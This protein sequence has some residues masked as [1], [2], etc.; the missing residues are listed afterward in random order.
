MIETLVDGLDSSPPEAAEDTKTAGAITL[1]LLMVGS[2]K[3]GQV[4]CSPRGLFETEFIQKPA[5]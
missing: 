4:V 5:A 2:S 3:V 1:T